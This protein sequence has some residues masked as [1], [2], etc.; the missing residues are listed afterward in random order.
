[1]MNTQVLFLLNTFL[2]MIGMGV[3]SNIF[4]RLIE[5]GLFNKRPPNNA[6]TT[7]YIAKTK[8]KHNRT[9]LL[10]ALTALIC[11]PTFAFG[12]RESLS[13]DLNAYVGNRKST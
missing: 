4:H 8:K 1:M 13:Q 10:T 7:K 11:L 3:C 6:F 2:H 9:Q 12:G 5:E